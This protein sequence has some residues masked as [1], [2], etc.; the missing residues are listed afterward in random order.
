MTPGARP[1][2]TS[3]AAPVMKP[4]RMTGVRPATPARI[5]PDEGGDLEAADRREDAERI[6]RSGAW[7]RD[8]R[9]D[10]R[11][12]A[13]DARIV[14]PRP[15]AGHAF[16]RCPVSTAVRALAAVVLPMPISPIGQDVAAVRDHRCA[17]AQADRDGGHGLLAGHRRPVGHV[18]RAG[19]DP[20]A[21]TSEPPRPVA[22][23]T[24]GMSEATPTSMTVS[25]LRRRG[26][27]VD[28]GPSGQ[29]VRDHLGRDVE[30][31][32]RDARDASPR[33]RRPPR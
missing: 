17:D 30:R 15:A 7:T 10:R 11:D 32:G 19:A 25:R 29:E 33:D 14:E 13:R 31:V 5:D 1:A 20:C 18:R 9:P 4:S 22:S 2:A 28:R 16:D 23:G 21:S 12:L 24:S 26:E 27:D 3:A 6:G 8:A